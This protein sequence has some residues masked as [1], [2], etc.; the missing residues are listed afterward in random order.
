MKHFSHLNTASQLLSSYDCKEPFHHYIRK[1][2]AENKKHGSRDRKTISHLCYCYLRLGSGLP[3]LNILDRI[4]AGLFLCSDQP[5]T[6]LAELSPRLNEKLTQSFHEKVKVLNETIS[7]NEIFPWQDLSNGIDHE[8][9][10]LSHLVQPDLFLRIRPGYHDKVIG[11]LKSGNT[12]YYEFIAPD[13]MRLPNGFKAEEIFSIDKEVVV[14]DL[15][16]QRVGEF[17]A[18]SLSGNPGSFTCWDCCAA[19]GG[20]SILARDVLGDISLIV[21]DVRESIIANLRKRFESAE[22]KRYHSFVADLS[23][24][25]VLNMEPMDLII[26]DLPCTGSGTWGRTPEH[27]QCFRPSSIDKYASLQKNILEN[28]SGNLKKGGHL[29]YITCSVFKKENEEVVDFICSNSNLQVI[30]KSVIPGYMN[31]ADT[32]FAALLRNPL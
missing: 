31:K 20:K 28:I 29:L 27:L 25:P 18:K 32:M 13:S 22:I 9:F 21:S 7:P 10:S 2:F 24:E 15:S 16:S 12:D 1:Y 5:T 3:E 8:Q 4:I 30:E 6:L 11:K 14:Q 19:S 23:R 26:A 17:M